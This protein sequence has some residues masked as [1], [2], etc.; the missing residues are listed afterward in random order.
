MKPKALTIPV[1][2]AAVAVG[3]AGCVRNDPGGDGVTTIAVTSTSEGC[4]VATDTAPSGTLRFEVR[5]LMGFKDGT[6]NIVAEET[7][8][9]TRHVWSDGEGQA[10]FAGGT[11]RT[12]RNLNSR[13]RGLSYL[14]LALSLPTGSR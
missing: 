3:T 2:L 4:A 12:S 9:L 11:Y 14:P 7:D 10:W 8:E 5:N 1:V 6:R 13:W